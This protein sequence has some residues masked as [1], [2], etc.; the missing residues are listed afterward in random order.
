MLSCFPV[1]DFV[2]IQDP[3]SRL[4]V[5]FVWT[6]PVLCGMGYGL[7]YVKKIM[8]PF[9]GKILCPKCGYVNYPSDHVCSGCGFK[10][11]KQNVV[12]P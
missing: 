8:K 12:I 10:L 1:C 11:T 2:G 9:E 6:V 3:N 4:I 7:Y 5:F